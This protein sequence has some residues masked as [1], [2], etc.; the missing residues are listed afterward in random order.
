MNI[1]AIA[2][3]DRHVGLWVKVGATHR[4]PAVEGVLEKV[5]R[6]VGGWPVTGWVTLTLSGVQHAV[7]W[8]RGVSVGRKKS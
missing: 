7:P 6:H 5:V 2:L 4:R 1:R 8:Y 3:R